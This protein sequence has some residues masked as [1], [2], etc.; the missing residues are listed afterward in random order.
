MAALTQPCV[1]LFWENTAPDSSSDTALTEPLGPLSETLPTRPALVVQVNDGHVMLFRAG[2]NQVLNLTFEEFDGEF[3]GTVFQ[4]APVADALK[5]PDGAQDMQQAFGFR[6]FIPE[7][8]KHKRVWR[9]VLIASLFIQLLALGT[10]VFT[11]VV[12]DKVVVHR[13]QSTLAVIAMG[14]ALFAIFS[15]LLSWVRQYLVLH[16]GNRVDAVLGSA[17]FEHLLKLPPRYSES[18]PTGSHGYSN[19]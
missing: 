4:F 3:T 13:T 10:P 11:Q 14:M 1:A 9:H 7:L 17:V 12:I 8:L 19:D 15:A 6:W 18:R 16:T 5:D 2:S